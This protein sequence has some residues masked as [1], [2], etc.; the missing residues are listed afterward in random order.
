MDIS[1]IEALAEQIFSKVIAILSKWGDAPQFD[2][3]T[4]QIA[5]ASISTELVKM[6]GATQAEQTQLVLE[7]LHKMEEKK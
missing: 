1:E 7:C 6:R 3:A 2:E 4:E 5:I